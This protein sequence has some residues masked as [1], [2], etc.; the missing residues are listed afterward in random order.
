[1]NLFEFYSEFIH[2][3]YNPYLMKQLLG[4]LIEFSDFNEMTYKYKKLY[5]SPT[6]NNTT[7][8]VEYQNNLIVE[9]LE[10][11]FNPKKSNNSNF[12]QIEKKKDIFIKY[13]KTIIKEFDPND[14]HDFLKKTNTYKKKNSPTTL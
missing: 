13:M 7:Q 1:M 2:L 5:S 12:N 8:M 6:S 4:K 14:T 11:L 9:T 10:N 3:Y